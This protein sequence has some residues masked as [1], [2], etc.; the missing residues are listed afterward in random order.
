[1]SL[2][3]FSFFCF[4]AIALVIYYLS[5]QRI[6]KYVLF[7][8]SIIFFLC[9]SGE[10]KIEMGLILALVIGLTYG[11]ARLI[12]IMENRKRLACMGVVISL[13]VMNLV[14]LKYVFNIG[15][16]LLGLFSI[17]ADISWLDFAAPIGISYFTLSAVGYLV[18]V[19]WGNYAAEKNFVVVADFVCFFPHM[20]SGPVCR[21]GE[22]GVQFR[23]KHSLE[24]ENIRLGMMRMLWG[25]F[26]KLVIADR[27][28][29]VV[30]VIFADYANQSSVMLWFGVFGYA[31]QLYGDFSGCM[32]IV[33]GAGRLFGIS[34]PENFQS[35]FFSL[36][37]PEFWRRWHITLGGWFKDFIMYP[38]LKTKTFVNLGKKAKK[39]LGKNM[40]KKIPTYLSLIVVWSLL[41]LWHGGVP[42]FYMASAVIPCSYLILGD[43][44]QPWFEKLKVK[45]KIKETNP[46]FMAF[47]MSR[48][49]LL[50]AVSWIFSNTA[51]VAEGFGAMGNLVTNFGIKPAFM[52]TFAQCGIGMEKLLV[53]FAAIVLLLAVDFLEWK[54]ISVLGILDK[55]P[56][57][58]RW[59][60]IYLV[61]A[62]VVLYGAVGT[63]AFI[64]FQF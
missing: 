32:D 3:D 18:E 50:I 11:G 37:V 47:Q 38:V 63:S 51:T 62:C 4:L 26:K 46:I 29:P 44:F 22:L 8:C 36:T 1:M 41:G 7:A 34:L 10:K 33:L 59:G 19:Y 21:F 40:G 15:G 24:Y 6:Q 17:E 64:Y 2:I 9:A 55:L 28:A 14:V 39:K 42:R 57:V 13:I 45:L 30:Q 23:E 56:T 5:S 20:I 43:F 12:S 48:T 35:P 54:E 61:I 31:V 16:L 58:V 53:L 27:L 49:L 25:Y 52:A 60:A